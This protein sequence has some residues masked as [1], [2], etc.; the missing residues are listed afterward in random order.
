M[1]NAATTVNIGINKK[2]A[3]KQHS[4]YHVVLSSI[5]AFKQLKERTSGQHIAISINKKKKYYNLSVKINQ[6]QDKI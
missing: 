2:L 5:S 4:K 1:V 3:V 6:N